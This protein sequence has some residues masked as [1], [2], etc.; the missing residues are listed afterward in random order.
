MTDISSEWREILG[1]IEV[2]ALDGRIACPTQL[3]NALNHRMES[4][5]KGRKPED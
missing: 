4:E 1:R 3:P 5:R 2:I